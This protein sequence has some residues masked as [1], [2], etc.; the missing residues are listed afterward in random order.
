MSS[1]YRLF[2]RRHAAMVNRLRLEK[3]TTADVGSGTC[4][5]GPTAAKFMSSN[6]NWLQSDGPQP[7][8]SVVA[9]VTVEKKSSS[10]MPVK[11]KLKGWAATVLTVIVRLNSR[12]P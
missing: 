7:K 11:S 8:G 6:V 3:R 9:A 12:A 2:R 5:G 1:D 10:S 4:E